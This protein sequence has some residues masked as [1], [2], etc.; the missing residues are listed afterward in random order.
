MAWREKFYWWHVCRRRVLASQLR[1]F[2]GGRT[3]LNILDIGCGTGENILLLKEFG[4]VTGLDNEARALEL[5]APR[6]YD[7]LVIGRAEEMS[8]L[9][10]SF[11]LAVA[12]D[13]FEHIEDDRGAI[14]EAARVL[15][16]GGFLLITVPAFQF[17]WS[18][19]DEYLLHKRRYRKSDLI[20]KCGDVGF[21][22][23]RSSYFMMPTVPAVILRRAIEKFI[24]QKKS[25]H[26]FDIIPPPTINRLLISVVGIENIMLR[27]FN[28]PFGT[29][30]FLIA[31]KQ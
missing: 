26:S 7:K 1:R 27:F 3:D 12:L 2:L 15:R 17:L 18:A 31:Q 22:V 29:S 14:R 24:S 23:K 19:H 16:P 11:D 9:D 8:F 5:A 20:K 13:V 6:G 21:A 4:R 25:P 30:I 10:R 28:L